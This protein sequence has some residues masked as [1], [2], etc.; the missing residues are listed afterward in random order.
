MS[1]VD[2]RIVRMQ[3]DNAQ[4]EA[5]VMRSMNTLDKLNEKLQFKEAAKGASALQVALSSIE[6]VSDSVLSSAMSGLDRLSK[7]STT[8]IGK[9]ADNIKTDI[10]GAITSVIKSITSLPDAAMN[11]IK[12][13][14]W[15]R[16]NNIADAQFRIEG[17][18]Y[19]WEE[20]RKAADY[21]VTDT[22][23]GLDAAAKAASQLAASGVD[24]QKVIERTGDTDLT[25]MH[26]ALRG[27]SGVAAMT[28]SSFDEIAN[29]FTKVAGMG[30][31]HAT[32]LNSI[33]M[34]GI[35]A[36]AVLADY[37]GVTEE[38]IHEM[39]RKSLIDFDT[40]AMAMDDAFGEHA[41]DANKTFSGSLANMKAALSRIGAIF[42]QPVIDKTNTLFVAVTTRIKEFQAALND[43]KNEDGS[44]TARF[45]THFAEA[46]E[47]AIAAASAFVASLDLS[48]FTSVGDTLDK[49]AI[50]VKGVFDGLTNF[51]NK[52]KKGVA[53]ATGAVGDSLELDL[54]DLDLLHRILQNEF[55]FVEERWAKLDEIYKN[56]D[57]PKT[58]LWLQGYMDQLAAVGYNFEKLG[59]TE[60]ELTKKFEEQTKELSNQEVLYANIASVV[61]FFKTVI[62][63]VKTAAKGL[64][65]GLLGIGRAIGESFLAITKGFNEGFLGSK[66]SETFSFFSAS[67][68]KFAEAVRPS[69][70]IMEILRGAASKV[71][72]GLSNVIVKVMEAGTSIFK[73]AA[74]ILTGRK[75][76]NQLV[77]QA[78]LTPVENFALGFIRIF[79]NF[80]NI[81]GNALTSVGKIISSFWKAFKN[82]FSAST[83]STG[84]ATVTDK[85]RDLSDV[86]KISDETAA[87][88]QSAFEAILGVFSKFG[89]VVTKVFS[90]VSSFFSKNKGMGAFGASTATA[91][92]EV[93]EL[94]KD[95]V[96]V[97]VNAEKAEGIFYRLR[98]IFN[99]VITTLKKAPSK[100]KEFFELIKNSEG[101]A[102]MKTS[103]EKLKKTIRETFDTVLPPAQQAMETF[104]VTADDAGEQTENK[105]VTAIN[106][107]ADAIT[108]VI[109]GLT[110]L[111]KKLPEWKK[112]LED[113]FKTI[114]T[115]AVT[116]Y[117]F[118][119]EKIKKFGEAI[120]VDNL[121]DDISEIWKNV[122]DENQ[123]LGEHIG[124][125][126]STFFESITD[127]LNNIDW[128]GVGK[129][130]LLT[131]V[132]GIMYKFFSTMNNV[133]ELTHN[134]AGIPK[135]ISGIFKGIGEIF[136]MATK[137]MGRMTN[138]M[139]FMSYA[140]AMVMLCGALVLIADLP[141]EKTKDALSVM[142]IMAII[143]LIISKATQKTG[144]AAKKLPAIIQKSTNTFAQIQVQIPKLFGIAAVIAGIVLFLKVMVDAVKELAPVLK[145]M[146]DQDLDKLLTIL[147][148]TFGLLA[149]LTVILALIGGAIAGLQAK[150]DKN[151]KLIFDNKSFVGM[152][153][154]IA[155]LV[156]AIGV[157]VGL[158]VKAMVSLSEKDISAGAW[159]TVIGLLA[160]FG[161]IAVLATKFAKG[162][163][164]KAILSAA[165]LVA[166]IA[167]SIYVVLTQ[168]T[169]LAATMTLAEKTGNGEAMVA[170][171]GTILGTIFIIGAS[172]GLLLSSLKGLKVDAVKQVKIILLAI[173]AI[174]LVVGIAITMIANAFTAYDDPLKAGGIVLSTL[175]VMAILLLAVQKYT[176]SL[177]EL[178]D[179]K[180]TLALMGGFTA[181]LLAIGAS[182]VLISAAVAISDL[183]S[184]LLGILGAVAMFVVVAVA[185]GMLVKAFETIKPDVI[186]STIGMVCAALLA[187]S[188]A[189]VIIAAAAVVFSQA[190]FGGGA[191]AIL[192]IL[193][194]VGA[195]AT[196][197]WFLS[198]M[199]FTKK[200][201]DNIVDTMLTLGATMLMISISALILAK[202]CQAM[203]G[204]S[205]DDYKRALIPI[206]A[207][208]A[209]FGGIILAL[210]LISSIG[211]SPGKA[212][213]AIIITI[214]Q[215]VADAFFT[216]AKACLA[217]GAAVLLLGLGAGILAGGLGKLSE[218]LA[219]FAV[220]FEE[221]TAAIVFLV[222]LIGIVAV[223]IALLIAKLTNFGRVATKVADAVGEKTEGFGKKFSDVFKGI[224]EKI[225]GAPEALKK[226]W[227]SFTPKAK[228]AIA[229]GIVTILGGLAAATPEA[230]EQIGTILM[231]VLN[232]I[233]SIVPK[234]VGWLVEFLITL[235]NGL[236]EQIRQKS[237]RIVAAIYN[238]LEALGELVI[239]I[240]ASLTASMLGTIFKALGL[241]SLAEAVGPALAKITEKGVTALRKGQETVDTYAYSVNKLLGETEELNKTNEETRKIAEKNQQTYS[242]L[243]DTYNETGGS[244]KAVLTEAERLD[245]KRKQYY[246]D[247]NASIK[248][249][250]MQAEA[251]KNTTAELAKQRGEM[252]SI[253]EEAEDSA[254]EP[255]WV[256]SKVGD[257][258]G[259]AKEFL[260]LDSLI[261]DAKD[262]MGS[263]INMESVTDQLTNGVDMESV[264]DQFT[265][266]MDMES[267]QDYMNDA[268]Y[269]S[270]ES[271]LDG[272]TEGLVSDSAKQDA[273]DAGT[274]LT[275]ETER[276]INDS[277]PKIEAASYQSNVRGLTNPMYANSD[278]YYKSGYNAQEMIEKGM[279]QARADYSNQNKEDAKEEAHQYWVAFNSKDGIDAHSPSKKFYKSGLWCVLGLQQ[280][281]KDNSYLATGQAE[282]LGS[283]MVDAIGS[284][285]DYVS[286]IAS[287]DIEYDP[288][289]RPVMDLSGVG[290]T[291]TDVSSMFANQNVSLAGMTG[292]I[293]Y[294]MT[295]LNGSNA[296]VVSELQALREDMEYMTEEM[297]NMQIVMDTGA[298]VGSTVGAYDDALGRRA[299]Y[300]E[301]GN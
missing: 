197:I 18:G 73:F 106:L 128:S 280:A 139:I 99:N 207:M 122:G 286:K 237:A 210:S 16:A 82:V 132:G 284:P 186:M 158:M 60:E 151:R 9:I 133:E 267:V 293:A 51:F 96:D 289:I 83:V 28:N 105:F 100:I 188:V 81:I 221:H 262:S 48:W 227:K 292:Q 212:T 94:S 35:N 120:G 175:G 194:L 111:F 248:K 259:K 245:G 164:H 53:D 26:K 95:V 288:R 110:W 241:D 148:Y 141:W 222:V 32:E 165:F 130:S 279:A 155:L 103:F 256:E 12:S 1:T 189:V 273:Y 277:K 294:D 235:I 6:G 136:K 142:T 217:M 190:S 184:V 261:G 161:A 140:A 296:A 297:T 201:M 104:G 167:G 138:A 278:S 191:A 126:I 203:H 266:G 102:N 76:I 204:I 233:I 113:F 55:G 24:F 69:I 290:R 236:A 234:L 2:N 137:S 243:V 206:G 226:K 38:D 185:L 72:E 174:V 163:N 253:G 195:L 15:K 228:V 202:A 135:E 37:L 52:T 176:K 86:F 231:T 39:T 153:V 118:F 123:T 59:W 3:F 149:G 146:T 209:L 119:S 154:G 196:L 92:K 224:K 5:G 257:I 150:S 50:R 250:T 285:L 49:V 11:Q 205:A 213:G 183:G 34:R 181:V 173:A 10:A 168:F 283:S 275:A 108:L 44:T 124:A 4:F 187:L 127:A 121:L 272:Y 85:V 131:L 21:A 46:W 216:F 84:I 68:A 263:A 192:S 90:K 182:L 20:V 117:N 27:I 295:T 252:T 67:F 157:A 274:D 291:A 54:Q 162:V 230:L 47:S 77:E 62:G 152:F 239:H 93:V 199:D 30:V 211:G 300:G 13:G 78:D 247:T 220:T 218:G 115:G 134:I 172:I 91:A 31:V 43:V 271:Y 258:A 208:L 200:K 144:E 116:V 80:K 298:L 254:N 214:M 268:G 8:I 33:S 177:V 19:S 265:S 223:V 63:G 299:V 287:G 107:V 58:G 264:T 225:N 270:S 87:N 246:S 89:N 169:I 75:T 29:I 125:F 238:L 269:D 61:E 147:V 240:F 17:L 97:S 255:S 79:T 215:G 180:A 70:S 170:A 193:L 143:L 7:Y 232:W 260:T 129:V 249:E 282:T 145:D 219:I 114:E 56:Q 244:I 22:A 64:L 178:G 65:G 23:Y 156:A 301:R 88:L 25:Q 45:A 276:A 36:A 242:K 57:S 159:G 251:L 74:D 98:I 66:I 71:S 179:W 40:F 166:L 229:T 101:V 109:D 281:I 198:K 171:I 42:A 160:L 112:D 41:K 14:G